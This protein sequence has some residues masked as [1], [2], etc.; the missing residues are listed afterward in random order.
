M[1]SVQN[2]A[3]RF[4]RRISMIHSG[5]MEQVE[6]DEFEHAAQEDMYYSKGTT[7]RKKARRASRDANNELQKYLEEHQKGQNLH[8][9]SHVDLSSTKDYNT[10]ST[11]R[12]SV[13]SIQSSYTNN[14]NSRFHNVYRNSWYLDS[15]DNN[16]VGKSRIFFS[17][18]CSPTKF[19]LM[20]SF[21]VIILGTAVG[22]YLR[23]ELNNNLE[24]NSGAT[25]VAQVASSEVEKETNTTSQ[26]PKNSVSAVIPLSSFLS[27]ICSKSNIKAE[28]G[29]EECFQ[30]CK[31]ATCCFV[32]D[33]GA[34][35][36]DE[37]ENESCDAYSAC[38][39]LE[40]MTSSPIPSPMKDETV[41]A[42]LQQH[43]DEDA[44][45]FI[46]PASIHLSQHCI[47]VDSKTQFSDCSQECT[48]AS[49]CIAPDTMDN[50]TNFPSSCYHGLNLNVCN[51]YKPCRAIDEMFSMLLT[52]KEK[53]LLS[54][55]C[56]VEHDFQKCSEM[57][58]AVACCL[59][60]SGPG[61]CASS[62]SNLCEQWSPCWEHMV[63]SRRHQPPHFANSKH[64]SSVIP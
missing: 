14:S 43:N 17:S 35:C 63:I 8:E 33:K 41:A 61:A 30:A 58:S 15:D 2:T 21:I 34:N 32:N 60:T 42:S 28:G 51:A 5:N 6:L 19:F 27:E 31:P 24:R 64:N 62:L 49:C 39:I 18:A 7:T 1:E 37:K 12:V 52:A 55:V 50:A 48:P 38:M 9:I 29:R 44:L 11:R 25:Q 57:C 45:F 20:T 40:M 10:S 22:I 16:Q 3:H 54:S 59:E 53:I 26:A 56:G 47:D 13:Q 23:I 4:G 36:L 46:P